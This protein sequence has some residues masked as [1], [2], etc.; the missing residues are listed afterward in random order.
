[1]P[2]PSR[3]L[4]QQSIDGRKRKKKPL[5]AAAKAAKEQ[6]IREY[7]ERCR[8]LRSGTFRTEEQRQADERAAARER[9]RRERQIE[10]Q[11]ARAIVSGHM[12][13]P[14]YGERLTA[15][16]GNRPGVDPCQ[17]LLIVRNWMRTNGITPARVVEMVETN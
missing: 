14:E 6:R 12:S 13:H 4:Q 11:R 5:S 3:D 17:L 9:N 16:I 2:S 8:Q 10:E 1:M 15:F 7:E